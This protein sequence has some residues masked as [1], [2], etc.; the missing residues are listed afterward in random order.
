MDTIS[1]GVLSLE[2]N[3]VGAELHTLSGAGA[4][5]GG[6]LW[7]G[8]AAWPRRAPLCFPWCGKL[9]DGWHEAGGVRYEGPQHGFARDM[10][11]TLTG[12]E[13]RRLAY[14][15]ASGPETERCYPWPFTLDTVH[16]LEGQSVETVCTVT[17]TGRE[18]MPVQLG[19]HTGLRCPFS[20]D[21]AVTDYLVRFEQAERPHKVLCRAGLVTGE[22]VPVFTGQAE[23]PL[24]PHLFDEDSIC[25]KGLRSAW[26]QLE[27]RDTG[28][29]LRL[30]ISG[31]DRVLL[32]SQPGI[33]GF[34][35]I[36][37]WCGLPSREDGAHDLFQRPC[38]HSLAPGGTFS[39]TQ[40]LTVI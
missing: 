21:R 5:E 14:R 1:N 23:I 13:E 16:T 26:V 30:D 18:P 36:E 34:L 28:R 2:V 27:E 12:R 11:H 4:P 35:C 22:E 7:D 3:P 10:V 17:N 20:P 32:W 19:F 29:A 9:K 37:P 8:G 6:W 24:E 15:L 25:L 38:A 39:R 31:F 40:R 33:P